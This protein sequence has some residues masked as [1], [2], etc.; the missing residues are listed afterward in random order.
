MK[1]FY[2]A[3]THG[4]LQCL[5]FGEGLERAQIGHSVYINFYNEFYS[6]DITNIE[7]DRDRVKFTFLDDKRSYN[8]LVELDEYLNVNAW[9]QYPI[10]ASMADEH[11]GKFTIT[12][13]FV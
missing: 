2:K 4:A 6:G 13:I 9:K 3:G 10:A 5:T 7:K 1:N 8:I 12:N 11:V